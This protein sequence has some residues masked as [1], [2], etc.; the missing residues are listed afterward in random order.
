[1]IDGEFADDEAE[2]IFDD[3][4]GLELN[5]ENVKRA[6]EEE[7]EFVKD[8]GLYEP[9]CVAHFLPSLIMCNQQ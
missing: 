2:R 4:T 9:L 5:L 6:R 1:M 7:I 8:L 3:L